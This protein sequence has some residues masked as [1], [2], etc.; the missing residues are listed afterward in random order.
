[1]WR[2]R[3]G[4]IKDTSRSQMFPLLDSQVRI[5]GAP[6]VLSVS[7]AAP[8][9]KCRLEDSFQPLPFTSPDRALPPKSAR[10]PCIALPAS[11]DRFWLVL[12]RQEKHERHHTQHCTS[13][14]GSI[15]TYLLCHSSKH[16]FNHLPKHPHADRCTQTQTH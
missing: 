15:E 4:S 10:P 5:D 16:H 6:T 8:G 3:R 9:R 11:E 13:S 14:I 12:E 1:M 7:T 2:W